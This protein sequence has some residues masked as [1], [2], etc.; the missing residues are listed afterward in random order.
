VHAIRFK[1]SEPIVAVS[2]GPFRANS[3]GEKLPGVNPG[4]RSSGHFGPLIGLMTDER[5]PHRSD[6]R[7]PSA[8]GASAGSSAGGWPFSS[9]FLILVIAVCL[10]SRHSLDNLANIIPDLLIVN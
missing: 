5:K 8:Y 9:A 3:G 7:Y 2:H 4:L 6:S 10:A 1:D